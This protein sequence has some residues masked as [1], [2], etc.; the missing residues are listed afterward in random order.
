MRHGDHQTRATL[1][2]YRSKTASE[3]VGV[4]MWR[5]LVGRDIQD[6]YRRIRRCLC[7][8]PLNH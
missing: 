3:R 5:R 1:V 6:L 8:L 2:K 4:V 7:A